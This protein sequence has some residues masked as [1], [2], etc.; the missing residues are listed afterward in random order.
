MRLEIQGYYSSGQQAVSEPEQIQIH[1]FMLVFRHKS[2]RYDELTISERIGNSPRYISFPEGGE[3]ET[4]DN[5]A[6]DRWLASL[7]VHTVRR[8]ISLIERH[9]GLALATAFGLVLLLI[10]FVIKGIPWS[11]NALAIH[12]PIEWR[13]KL[14]QP[15]EN[16]LASSFSSSQLPILRQQRLQQRFQDWTQRSKYPYRLKFV[17]DDKTVN[18]FAL[19][20]GSIYVT[21]GLVDILASDEEVL[22]VIAHEMGHVERHHGVEMLLET[23]LLSGLMLVAFGDVTQLDT[24]S[25]ALPTALFQASYSR[26][27][28]VEADHFALNWMRCNGE[29]P[30]AVITAFEQMLAYDQASQARETEAQETEDL[31]STEDLTST[32]LSAPKTGS[33]GNRWWDL[34]STHPATGKRIERLKEALQQPKLSC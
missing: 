26:D 16:M 30:E 32:D 15:A 10:L 17:R 2:Y 3:F 25:V 1:S 14:S 7:D 29:A 28:E 21:D 9:F 8:K 31:D 11:A 4:L 18:A 19:P 33:E 6:I 27:K 12:I 13:V 5:E 24:L 34:F 20:S 23:S 22:A